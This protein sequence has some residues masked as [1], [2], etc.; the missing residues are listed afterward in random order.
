MHLGT[1]AK[2]MSK[3]VPAIL[4]SKTLARWNLGEKTRRRTCTKD[5]GEGHAPRVR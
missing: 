4:L 2:D 3:N 1:C 5:V